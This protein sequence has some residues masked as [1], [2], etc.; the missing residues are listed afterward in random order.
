[1]S[2]VDGPDDAEVV[3]GRAAMDQLEAELGVLRAAT[4]AHYA[5]CYYPPHLCPGRSV[6][7]Y[8]MDLPEL[9]AKK[10]LVT[11]VII[12]AKE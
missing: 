12:L 6:T 5:H 10:L 1:M 3:S 9:D 4:R 2:N 7:E 8:I 11:A